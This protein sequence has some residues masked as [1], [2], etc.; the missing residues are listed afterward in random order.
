MS[1]IENRTKVIT[2]V[3]NKAFLFSRMGASIHQR[4]RRKI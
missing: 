4:W 2:G 1:K 3:N